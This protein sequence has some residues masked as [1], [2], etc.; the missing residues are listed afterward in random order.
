MRPV[1]FYIPGLDLPVYGYGLMLLLS[2]V[3]GW[4]LT[5]RLSVRAGLP[6]RAVE[7]VGSAL[8]IGGFL[9]AKLLDVLIGL[10]HGVDLRELLL[11][12][13]GM[14]AYGGV[15]GACAAAAWRCHRLGVP[16]GLY[17]DQAVL[18][19][20]IAFGL[21]RIGCFLRGCDFGTLA[22]AHAA[23]AVRFPAD[24]PAF[25]LHRQMLPD[26]VAAAGGAL[27]LPV[28]PT[29]LYESAVVFLLLPVLLW[30]R[31]RPHPD[32]LVFWTF[33]ALYGVARFFLE[34]LR[35]DLDRGGLGP[36]STS[37]ILAAL[38]LLVAVW[39]AASLR[40]GAAAAAPPAFSG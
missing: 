30:V 23:F 17:A 12:W 26:A 24:S 16:M 3:I 22:P 11:D 28:H 20:P 25:L 1:L 19:V 9:G 39:A 35:A 15:I 31:R 40:R 14:V 37:Q 18:G 33:F 21:C 32:G 2:M 7:S 29:Q 36:L 5:L 4:F 8:L 6:A 38:S 10:G 13:G 34:T 27:S